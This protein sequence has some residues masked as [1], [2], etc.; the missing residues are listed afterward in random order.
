MRVLVADDADG[1]RELVAM[2]LD[3]E[4]DFRVVAQARDGFEAVAA[5]RESQ[6]DLVVLDVSMPRLDGPAALPRIRAC[7]PGSRV[8]LFTGQRDAALDREACAAGA[9]AVLSK[10]VG[11]HTLVGLLREVCRQQAPAR[12][13]HRAV[14]SG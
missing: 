13:Q 8:V 7:S 14:Q 4:P 10:D 2:L 11:A 5:A 3:M 1:V 12:D 6:P 9:D